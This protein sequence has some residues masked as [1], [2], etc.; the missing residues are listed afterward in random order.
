MLGI[1]SSIRR[2]FNTQN[3]FEMETFTIVSPVIAT[4]IS[5]LETPWWAV[6]GA[7]NQFKRL[8]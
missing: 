2:S 7:A 8:N 6:A 1:Y 4:I 3:M 5:H